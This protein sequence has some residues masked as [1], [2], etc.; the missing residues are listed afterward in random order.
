MTRLLLYP[1]TALLVACST[2]SIAPSKQTDPQC[3][4]SAF[5]QLDKELID[6]NRD[7]STAKEG[8]DAEAIASA[9]ALVSV[10]IAAREETKAYCA[11]D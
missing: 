5:A 11:G 2:A 10:V 6:A 4:A 9:E 1:I 8:T 3:T 7:L